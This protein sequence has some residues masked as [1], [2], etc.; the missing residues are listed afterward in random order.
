MI[1]GHWHNSQEGFLLASLAA[2]EALLDTEHLQQQFQ[3]ALKR[4]IDQYFR[5]EI[6]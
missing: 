2:E 3:G 1:L 4:L 5:N 6:S